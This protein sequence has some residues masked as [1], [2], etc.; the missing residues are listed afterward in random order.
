MQATIPANT[1]TANT[2][3][4]PMVPRELATDVG[5]DTGDIDGTILLGRLGNPEGPALGDCC[6]ADGTGTVTGVDVGPTLGRLLTTADDGAGEGTVVVFTHRLHRLW[7]GQ[8]W[9]PTQ[10]AHIPLYLGQYPG[11]VRVE[12]SQRG[13][14]VLSG[15]N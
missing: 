8:Y 3:T 4:P 5:L 1:I 7:S 10:V 13:Q 9:Q 12:L 6:S 2:G 14:Y 11:P 15:H